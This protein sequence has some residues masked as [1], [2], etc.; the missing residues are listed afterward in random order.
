MKKIYLTHVSGKR[1][2]CSVDEKKKKPLVQQALMKLP[3]KIRGECSP[4]IP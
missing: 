4:L 2:V 3:K 1:V